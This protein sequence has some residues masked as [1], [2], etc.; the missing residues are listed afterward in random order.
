MDKSKILLMSL[1]KGKIGETNSSLLGLIA[2]AKL[3]MA[4][5]SRA[6]MPEDQRKDFYLYIDEFQNFVTDSIA[7]ILSEARKYK[8][9]LCLGHQF[10]S[11]LVQNNDTRVRDAVFGNVGNLVI[12]RVGVDDSELLAK[13]L[14][15]VVSEYDIMNIEKFNAYFRMMI[16]NTAMPAFNMKCYHPY[17][18][19]E[20]NHEITGPIKELSRLKFGRDRATVM[21]EIIERSQIGQMGKK[22]ESPADLMGF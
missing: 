22:S 8:L 18:L 19:V 15:P 21:S 9:D 12:Y 3:Q 10:I 6:D 2:V 11:Q 4:A 17:T 5:L 20:P 13:Q 1:S 7:V 16:D 14:A